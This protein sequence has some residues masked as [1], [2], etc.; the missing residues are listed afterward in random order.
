MHGRQRGAVLFVALVMLLVLTL[1]AVGGMREMQLEG[2]MT[3]NRLELQRLTS[4]AE[5]ALREGEGRV[6]ESSRA[7]EACSS[8]AS[9]C[10]TGLASSYAA[11]FSSTTA[12]TGL[13]GATSLPRNARWY[14]RYIGNSCKGG[15]GGSANAYLSKGQAGCTYYYE[16]NAQAYKDRASAGC[17][18]NTLCLRSSTAL[19][20]P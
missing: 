14:L 19:V 13:D 4:A 1:L 2:R 7:L 20:I 11:D 3:G 10:Y 5:S 8:S 9:P 17:A 18:A 16:V 6:S 15:S 12:Y